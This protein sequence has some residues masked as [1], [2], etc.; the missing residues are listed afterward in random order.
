LVE[1]NLSL[2]RPLELS[3]ERWLGLDWSWRSCTSHC[4][5][6][7]GFLGRESGVYHLASGEHATLK[8]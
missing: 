2:T 7:L 3:N 4:I 8:G 5:D 6:G 1:K